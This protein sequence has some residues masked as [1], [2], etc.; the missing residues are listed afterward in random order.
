MM[1]RMRKKSQESSN[2]EVM[3][4]WEEREDLARQLRVSPLLAQLLYNRGIAEVDGAR[5]FLRPSFKNL[6][7]PECLIGV[8][9]AV[10]RIRQAMTDREKVVLYGDYD[11]DGIAGVAILW[12]CFK[13]AGYDVDYY[14][15]HRIDEGY[16]LNL[17]AIEHLAGQGAQLIISID[18][19]INA[20]QVIDRGRE[21]GVDIIVTDHHKLEEET[22]AA[23]ITV[24]PD[25]PGQ[26]YANPH[27]CGAGVALKLA[28]ALSQ[29]FC[30]RDKVTDEF[31]EYLI[32]ATG[33]AALGTVADVV[34]LVGENRIIASFGMQTLL[35]SAN[36]GVRALLQGAGVSNG[37][38][39]SEDVGFKLAPR[40]NA[41]GRMG[42][43]RLAVEL[44]TKSNEH[45]AAEIVAYL[46]AQNRQRQKVEKDIADEAINQI[47][48]LGMDQS[49]WRGY[50]VSGE[51]WHPGVIGIVASRI[52][53]KFNRPTLVIAEGAEKCM[54]SGRSVQ[55]FDLFKA[56]QSCQEFLIRFGGHA[57][58][59]GLTCRA[60]Q[61]EPL[62]HSFNQYALD[63]F[64]E[65]DLT[66]IMSIDAQVALADLDMATVQA[67]YNL[68][69]F[70]AGNPSVLLMSSGLK[71]VKPPQKMGARGDHLALI[72][73]AKDTMQTRGNAML[74]A[75]GFNL[76]KWEKKLIDAESFSLVY[77]PVI[78]HFNG[79]SS[80]EMR[81][82]DIRIDA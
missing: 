54:G 12:Q 52:V 74:R 26:K 15:P 39:N 57:M 47:L 11:V 29:D 31:R 64:E 2:W 30:G 63:H 46:D 8:R 45:R 76:S 68:G 61:I 21:L 1:A 72:V 23:P 4:A 50:V 25:L 35:N 7:D 81:I 49:K 13:L 41:A 32:F 38:I 67:I 33:L 14:V 42:H 55:G 58:A 65:G 48:K 71:L 3:P 9:P 44:F 79:N 17:E 69:P 82:Y 37:K 27:L 43:A 75:V 10:K 60:D 78:N 59:A 70:G 77:E 16:G 18:C 28:W 36:P 73:T 80:V 56:L 34:P 5:E 51:N 22:P 62:R 66:R 53:D 19:G 40:L 24:H 20:R 6:I